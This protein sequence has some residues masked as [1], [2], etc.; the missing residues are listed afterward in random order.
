MVLS[1]G[2]ISQQ[3]GATSPV[4]S[5]TPP[6]LGT[7]HLSPATSSSAVKSPQTQRSAAAVKS[8]M[9]SILQDQPVPQ[10]TRVTGPHSSTAAASSQSSTSKYTHYGH[11]FQSEFIK[12]TAKSI[13]GGIAKAA[14]SARPSK[15]T[16]V[17][18]ASGQ[19]KVPKPDRYTPY[20]T[21]VKPSSSH[22]VVKTPHSVTAVPKA[23]SKSS[24]APKKVSPS[25][26]Y[27]SPSSSSADLAT[28]LAAAAAAQGSIYLTPTEAASL[29]TAH[30]QAQ[31][32]S[33][34]GNLGSYMM[35][36]MDQAALW[37]AS[38]AQS[39]SAALQS[40]L[41]SPTLQSPDLFSSSQSPAA[42]GSTG[43]SPASS[44]TPASSQQSRGSNSSQSQARS[45]AVSGYTVPAH[46]QSSAHQADGGKSVP[47]T[48]DP[49]IIVLSGQ[50]SD[51]D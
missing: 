20:P 51:E 5:R 46:H 38:L 11:D 23:K 48:D 33:Q 15:W 50:D 41:L 45:P 29:A 32:L 27:E 43:R 18:P 26:M 10:P 44:R 12:S 19:L 22:D 39:Y 17:K 9:A 40:Q 28:A 37:A 14:E 30:A 7:S 3:L 13:A 21:Q 47:K 2:Q 24:G 1:Q 42:S 16:S 31:A 25:S 35:G 34:W 49:D 36:G 8:I 4:R 6:F